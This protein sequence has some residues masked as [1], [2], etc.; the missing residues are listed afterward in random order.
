VLALKR[1]QEVLLLY[2]VSAARLARFI[3]LH[4]LFSERHTEVSPA[5]S[6]VLLA[7]AAADCWARR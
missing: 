6:P 3:A 4:D 7:A 5:F 2:P 1:M